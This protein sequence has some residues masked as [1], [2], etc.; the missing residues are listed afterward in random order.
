MS[1]TCYFVSL[2]LLNQVYSELCMHFLEDLLGHSSEFFVLI[3]C[4][5]HKTKHQHHTSNLP[6]NKY[7][8]TYCIEQ[9]RHRCHRFQYVICSQDIML[10]L[11]TL[12]V[13]LLIVEHSRV[14]GF[15]SSSISITSVRSQFLRFFRY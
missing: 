13:I 12:L 4:Q 14:I 1:C 9:L 8:H 2:L 11:Q 3:E 5:V 15:S 7:S 6:L 10:M